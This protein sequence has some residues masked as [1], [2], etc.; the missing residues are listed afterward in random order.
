MA[1]ELIVEELRQHHGLPCCEIASLTTQQSC[2]SGQ[3][4]RQQRRSNPV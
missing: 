3:L 1:V 4:M 2:F